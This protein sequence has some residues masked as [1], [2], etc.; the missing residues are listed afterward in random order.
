MLLTTPGEYLSQTLALLRMNNR[1]RPDS[2]YWL[3]YL[4]YK[5]VAE[6]PQGVGYW[7][8]LS[9]RQMQLEASE[10]RI[11]GLESTSPASQW[12]GKY[13]MGAHLIG[14]V[15]ICGYTCLAQQVRCTVDL[16]VAWERLV[17]RIAANK[18]KCLHVL[19]SWRC[20]MQTSVSLFLW[21]WWRAHCRCLPDL[22]G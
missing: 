4:I 17:T 11:E 3:I 12:P 13:Q 14:K 19:P 7:V 15:V 2:I 1:L 6:S 20:C 10:E 21:S 16:Q 9:R 8:V 18:S 22:R 5:V